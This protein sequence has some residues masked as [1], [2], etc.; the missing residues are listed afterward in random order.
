[1]MEEPTEAIRRQ[2]VASFLY[3]GEGVGAY[4]SDD[5]V[6][7]RGAF[8]AVCAELGVARADDDR[9]DMIARRIL[10]AYET[11]RRAPLY[12]VHAGLNEA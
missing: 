9:R 10:T 6:S 3:G 1:M 2:R 11:G 5:M 8:D 7:M 4:S 12:L